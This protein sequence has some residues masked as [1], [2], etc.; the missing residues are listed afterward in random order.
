[1]GVEDH[2]G[3]RIHKKEVYAFGHF[4]EMSKTSPLTQHFD[5][6][7]PGFNAANDLGKGHPIE[8]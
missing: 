1:M 7:V 3:Y 8:F 2:T 4:A 5:P 6:G